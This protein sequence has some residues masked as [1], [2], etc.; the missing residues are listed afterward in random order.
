MAISARNAVPYNG[1][2][3]S[4]P[5]IPRCGTLA[6]PDR[7]TLRNEVVDLRLDA[8]AH[9]FGESLNQFEVLGVGRAVAVEADRLE[10]PD[11]ELRE[12]VHEPGGQAEVRERVVHREVDE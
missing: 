1:P 10:E 2:R 3:V 6:E 4:I 8:L 5:L 7:L 11:L 12:Q 9:L